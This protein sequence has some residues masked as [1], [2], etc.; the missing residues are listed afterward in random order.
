[1]TKMTPAEE[2][3]MET[4]EGSEAATFP[5]IPFR[6]QPFASALHHHETTNLRW[7]GIEGLQWTTS[8]DP[9]TIVHVAWSLLISQ[10]TNSTDI[11]MGRATD[12][13]LIPMRV[14]VD[15][16]ASIAEVTKAVRQHTQE[17]M[18]HATCHLGKLRSLNAD[19]K[20]ACAFQFI[21]AIQDKHNTGKDLAVYA[22]CAM[23]VVCTI[24]DNGVSMQL[25][26]DP[27]VMDE[28]K[29]HLLA[30][31][32]DHLVR[33]LTKV[34]AA[35]TLRGIDLLSSRDRRQIWS[36]NAQVPARVDSTLHQVFDK[37]AAQC[38]HKV[39]VDSWDG[40]LSYRDL[41]EMSRRLSSRLL[42]QGVIA[43]GRAVPVCIEKSIWTTVI[44]L[45]IAQ[46]GGIFVVLDPA[47][48]VDH[49][50]RITQD[51]QA[52]H[53][54]CTPATA[55]V[56]CDIGVPVYMLDGQQI[57]SMPLL[58]HDAGEPEAP[59]VTGDSPLYVVYTSGSTGAAKGLVISHGNLCSA[60]HYQAPRLGFDTKTRSFDYSSYSFDAYIFNTFYTLLT[61]GC[62]CIPSDANRLGDLQGSLSRMNVNL[63]QLTPSVARLVDPRAVPAVQ[64]MI[65]T[66]EK[67]QPGD[68][69]RWEGR[70][71]VV[72]AYGPSE[73]TIMCAANTDMACSRDALSI[74]RGLG[75]VLW[76]QDVIN[77]SR[78]API[79][80][81]GEVVIEGPIVGLGYWRN[82]ELTRRVQVQ[83]PAWL[84]S[85]PTDH[86]RCGRAGIVYRTGDY[87]RYDQ[88]G[89]L[90][91]LGRADSQTKL[92]GQRIETAAVE[93]HLH[94]ILPQGYECAVDMVETPSHSQLLVG[95]LR[96][97]E[98]AAT[99]PCEM[100]KLV[101][102]I[103]ERLMSQ[104]PPFMVPSVFLP[105]AHIPMTASG[106]IDRRRLRRLALDVP[107]DAWVDVSG[108]DGSREDNRGRELTG[109]KEHLLARLWAHILG[110]HE[111]PIGRYDSFFQRGGES[112][113][114][115]KL[116]A[117]VVREGYWLDV[118]TV[119][120]NPRLSDMAKCMAHTESKGATTQG[121][122]VSS[123]PSLLA[124]A[125]PQLL[126][127][128]TSACNIQ[129]EDIEDIYR[130]SPIQEAMLAVTAQRPGSFVMQ[131]V[132]R[133]PQTIDAMKMSK[134]WESVVEAN[135][136]LRTRAV[137]AASTDGLLQVVV[138]FQRETMSRVSIVPRVQELQSLHQGTPLV[139]F[140]LTECSQGQNG[141]GEGSPA[142]VLTMHHALYDAWSLD[143][144]LGQLIQ[145]YEGKSI[146]PGIP[147]RDFIAYVADTDS[148]AADA[149]WGQ[150]L[151]T[152][153]APQFPALPRKDFQPLARSIVDHSVDDLVWPSR[154]GITPPN[155]VRAACAMLL[156]SYTNSRDVV[157]G[158]TVLGRQS[159]IPGI[160]RLA[161]PTIATV[162][163]RVELDW[164]YSVHSTLAAV[165]AQALDSIPF[166]QSG[167]S[168]IRRLNHGAEQACQ[169]QTLLV[170]QPRED[171]SD[172]KGTLDAAF[173]YRMEDEDIGAFS[174][175]ALTIICFLE[176][177]GLRLCFSFD[178]RVLAEHEARQMTLQM[179]HI[180][181]QLCTTQD[182][183]RTEL[184]SIETASPADMQQIWS[185]NA[186]VPET[187]NRC[188]HVDIAATAQRQP[189][190]I[191]VDGWDGQL[192]YS[193]LLRATSQLASQL[194]SLGVGPEVMVPTC[195]EK[196]TWAAVAM[197]AVVMAGGVGVALDASQPEDRLRAIIAQ[198][199]ARLVL[200]GVQ[201][202]DLAGE[203]A[204]AVVIV[205]ASLFDDPSITVLET[206]L[207][208]Q[209]STSAGDDAL[210]VVF[211]SGSTGTPKGAIITHSGFSS[212][213]KHQQQAFGM[214]TS[215]RVLDFASY[216]FDVAWFDL[217]HTLTIG[218]CLCIPSDHARRDNL[219]ATIRQFDANYLF[220]T[221]SLGRY[222]DSDCAP[223]IKD[224]IMGGEGVG[225]GDMTGWAEDVRIRVA[226]GPAECTVMSNVATFP[227]NQIPHL[228]HTGP[229][230]GVN[231]W[232]VSCFNSDLLAPVGAIGELVLE[233]PLLGRGYLGD[234]EKTAAAFFDDPPWLRRGCQGYHGGRRG[235][236]Y[237]TGD[238]VKLT[239]NG[240][241][242]IVGRRDAQVKIRGQ[243]VELEEVETHSRRLLSDKPFSTLAAEV[244]VARGQT[245]KMLA[246]FLV[247]SEPVDAAT[248]ANILSGL[249]EALPIYMVPSAVVSLASIPVT[250]TGKVNRKALRE[251]AAAMSIDQFFAED[252]EES[253]PCHTQ[254]KPPATAIEKKLHTL[255]T[256]VL[257]LNPAAC[258]LEDNFFHV[259]GDSV[260]AMRLAGHA[261]EQGMSLSVVT[262]FQTPRL[263]D[264]A[265]VVSIALESRSPERDSH[266]DTVQNGVE[267][268][269]SYAGEVAGKL[270]CAE[271]H[272]LNILP[273]TDFQQHSVECATLRP[274]AEWGF[275]SVTMVGAD[276][277]R[278][279]EA[280]TK[281]YDVVEIFRTIFV[282]KDAGSAVH[283][284][285]L[286]DV[287]PDV[288]V[289]DVHGT[290][291][292]AMYS[293]FKDDLCRSIQLGASFTA[294]KILFHP[295][296]NET[297]LV[298]RMSHAHYDGLS[299]SLIA[300]TL[301]AL[302][303]QRPL[304]RLVSFSQFIRESSLRTATNF[305][306]WRDVLSDCSMSIL[307]SK[308]Q[309]LNS[310]PPPSRSRTKMSVMIPMVKARGG[311]TAA[312]VI[313]ASW[314]RV[315][316][317]LTKSTDVV[318]GRLV[319][320]RHGAD[321]SH[322]NVIGPCI[323]FV[324][325]RT[326][327]QGVEPRHV[328]NDLQ[329]QYIR[330][331][332]HEALRFSEIVDNCTDWPV[333]TMYGS[334]VHYQNVE[335]EPLCL[336][337]GNRV[338]FEAVHDSGEADAP[339]CP[340]VTAYPAGSQ[341][342]L[343]LSMP[344]TFELSVGEKI[345]VD[346]A[347]AV[348]IFST[349]TNSDES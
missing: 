317:S 12:Q 203:L 140:S 213:T 270:F 194:R 280:C 311:I 255:W 250:A 161:G 120:K 83:D 237:R 134:A 338:R 301:A 287:R 32:I 77:S 182:P 19:T 245:S 235:R 196:S 347:D 42:S 40:Q 123:S 173:R 334:T 209:D 304:P 331:L 268:I 288:T 181:R 273:V 66:G 306:H 249:A 341:C 349:S 89:T 233:G 325:V 229:G 168:R 332:Q 44:I 252:G 146:V 290:L 238:L 342:K 215:S 236:V 220:L 28:Q 200:A 149:Y 96:E 105:L 108:S 62:L 31:Q 221:P 231:C 298:V 307:P 131:K 278:L 178:D 340:R 13:G 344:A 51:L 148:L 254:K 192:T 9:A 24:R 101:A 324:P 303:D 293:F 141:H 166:E 246:L 132:I 144:Y 6:Y 264:M 227:A 321:G 207:V 16:H 326:K 151:A 80:A 26:Y 165:Q 180:L 54:I 234:P 128:I 335:D 20:R 119:L 126:Q 111:T 74:G 35:T 256:K 300:E 56:G 282:P 243:R 1:M 160:Q 284:V 185:W 271:D 315:L 272:I 39:A 228:V 138:R 27:V 208:S 276:T 339:G 45:A 191:A 86:G 145:A 337:G 99:E 265:Q 177:E 170:V 230:L 55:N 204:P 232:V 190:A 248:K 152:T 137:D 279:R 143:L 263:V 37:V 188:V 308:P 305:Q 291:D 318:F 30:S 202:A 169:F 294:F 175:H 125:S 201:T 85:G 88:D 240:A 118:L 257:G 212:A 286:K 71:R 154:P 266:Q 253:D 163:V 58:D 112:I 124:E 142:I 319:S 52:T 102:D 155:M 17:A 328:L 92:H 34:D 81:V 22:N 38:P 79:G 68:L 21:L 186:A 90:V 67:I 187:V 320:G 198:T 210:F 59:S 345:L 348:Q 247:S 23:S 18:A 309:H 113:A 107:P 225:R 261:H 63:V 174:T 164:T 260:S 4:L 224:L 277:S 114:A 159:S 157:F 211:T 183:G 115:I 7:P 103:M 327:V 3:W 93:S 316:S 343:E 292:T 184:R 10:Y 2:F 283:A 57:Q 48:P 84:L 64:T 5:E 139:Y 50:S 262:I 73:C 136:I 69:A 176:R 110:N 43:P 97:P 296:T 226:Y 217:L 206:G 135:P 267:E 223:T 95:F 239:D 313:Y 29:I 49:L 109:P 195:F 70:A 82:E 259:G 15:W 76:L 330:G 322:G 46:Q 25:R 47:L 199:Q 60:A 258:G 310:Q 87:A 275:F 205:D 314:A 289:Q 189:D 98:S 302:Y 153:E 127:R 218:A 106:K 336:L 100:S 36:Y 295:A 312:T 162:P 14:H 33:Q 329:D 193:E 216:A 72:N 129:L 130:C 75:C 116:V 172:G 244:V 158:A 104:L 219:V 147:Y 285:V 65:L 269:S 222:L 133:L 333:G 214:T 121:N 297:R 167:I 346:L 94:E 171:D 251:V 53:V 242:V 241:L 179:E 91:F 122:M 299:L 78:L 11:V 61:G 117:A 197:L 150:L 323:N 8:N 274:R 281:L 156:A 41:L